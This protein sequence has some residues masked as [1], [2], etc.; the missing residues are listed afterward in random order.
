MLQ[1]SGL[2]SDSGFA[3]VT[4]NRFNSLLVL[5]FLC[6]MLAISRHIEKKIPSL[7][8]KGLGKIQ[9]L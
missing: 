6:D 2:K 9:L 7:I 5:A 1:R 4:V 8:L 3:D